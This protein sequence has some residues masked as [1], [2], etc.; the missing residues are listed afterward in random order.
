MTEVWKIDND[1]YCLHTEN[2]EVMKRIK[3]SYHDFEVM[4]E[5]F[6]NEKLTSIQYKVPIARKRSAFH[7]ANI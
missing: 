6:K 4:A 3:R 1:F 5:Y 2:K 7:L